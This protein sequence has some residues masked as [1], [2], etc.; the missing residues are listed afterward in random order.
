MPWLIRVGNLV[1]S[2]FPG[3]PRSDGDEA[4]ARR[5]R[6]LEERVARN[7]RRIA[8][9]NIKLATHL[10]EHGDDEAGRGS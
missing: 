2:L 1:R 4:E 3:Q 6:R 10:R 9:L 5:L 8:L 7:R